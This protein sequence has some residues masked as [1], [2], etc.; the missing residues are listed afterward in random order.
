MFDFDTNGTII[1][2]FIY[3]PSAPVKGCRHKLAGDLLNWVGGIISFI[4]LKAGWL[5]HNSIEQYKPLADTNYFKD[6][7]YSKD[8]HFTPPPC[9]GHVSIINSAVFLFICLF[10]LQIS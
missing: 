10:V 1:S 8:D 9:C 3:F 4:Q 5:L 7:I 6:N 2:V